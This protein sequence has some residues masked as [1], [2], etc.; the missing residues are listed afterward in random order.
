M[1]RQFIYKQLKINSTSINCIGN[2]EIAKVE[3]TANEIMSYE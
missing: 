2:F 1:N 3:K